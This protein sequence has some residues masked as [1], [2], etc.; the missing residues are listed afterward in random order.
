MNKIIIPSLKGKIRKGF[1]AEAFLF[2]IALSN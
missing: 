1:R 2:K